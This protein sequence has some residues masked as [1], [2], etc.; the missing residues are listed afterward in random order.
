M[1]R[2]P[3]GRQRVAGLTQ[4]VHALQID[5][6]KQT[7]VQMRYDQ[8]HAQIG[9]DLA[10]I[11][12]QEGEQLQAGAESEARLE[13]LDLELAALQEQHEAGQT[14]Y[15]EREQRLADA[16]QRL[17]ELERAAQEAQF[18]EKSQRSRIDELRR[19]IA[20]A[21]EQVTQLGASMQAGHSELAGL[22]DQAAQDG[23]QDLLD[24]R[25]LQ[26]RALADARHELDQL[27]QKL[28][29]LEESRMQTERG[30]QPQRERIM[31]LQLKKPA[32]TRP[33]WRRCWTAT[34][35]RHGC[36]GK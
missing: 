16:R 23:L 14:D 8:R 12:A 18:A 28:R 6:L 15:L 24:R 32:P 11:A 26:E 35:G 20:T 17:R 22:D 7:E 31:E 13:E 30:L 5:L 33:P 34:S 27:T 2:L 25:S 4:N 29:H 21:S 3:E 9:A 19:G 10:E 36:R 1:Q